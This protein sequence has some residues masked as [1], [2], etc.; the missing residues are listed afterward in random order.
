MTL[1]NTLRR[2]RL[3][4]LLARLLANWRAVWRA[5]SHGAVRPPL[6]FRSGHTLLHG[7]SDAPVFLFPED[8]DALRQVGTVVGEHHERTVPR[9]L[10]RVTSA[11]VRAGFQPGVSSSDRCGNMFFGTRA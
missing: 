11:L 1:C 9:V 4:A 5:C 3:Q 6:H 7:Q 10:A 2:L 8:G